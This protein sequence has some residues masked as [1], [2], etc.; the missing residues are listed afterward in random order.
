MALA[1]GLVVGPAIWG[2]VV[3][4]VMYAIPGR[5]GAGS[6][7]GYSCWRWAAVLIWRAPQSASTAD[8]ALRRD[9]PSRR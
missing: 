2:V 5:A 3:N 8:C 7:A 9:S 1:Q 6:R 4:L